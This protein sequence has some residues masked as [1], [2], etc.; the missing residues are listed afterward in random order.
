MKYQV[1][2]FR[3]AGLECKWGKVNQ[4]RPAI[5]VRDPNAKTKHQ[6]E[7]W[8]VCDK[9]MWDAMHKL[10]IIE[11]FNSATVFGDIFSVSA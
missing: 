3:D 8:W 4:G 1:K 10:G 9:P 7:K 11:G 6:R 2:T 5:F